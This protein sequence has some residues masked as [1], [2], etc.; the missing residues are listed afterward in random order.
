[1]G[2]LHGKSAIAAMFVGCLL[3]A[4]CSGG[5]STTA[6]IEA[7]GKT[8]WNQDGAPELNKQVII[9]NRSLAKDIEV[10]D[11]KSA[12]AGDLMRAQVSL[13]SRD[14]DTVNIQYRFA[15]FDPQG[16][17][18]GANTGAWKPFIVYGRETRTIQGVAPDPRAR[19]FKL[20]IREPDDN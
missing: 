18:I 20:Q 8:V 7:T 10:S 1:M 3:A 9:N 19:E 5:C 13:R 15:W 12:L 11:M 17:E 6:G 16:M 2:T 14:R 4:L